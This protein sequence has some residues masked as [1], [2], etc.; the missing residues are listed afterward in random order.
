MQLAKKV[1]SYYKN[2]KSIPSN[3]TAINGCASKEALLALFP[4]PI[5]W[6]DKIITGTNDGEKAQRI[7][8]V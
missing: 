5:Y 2:S 4:R 8:T 6:L 1:V 3:A 7:S